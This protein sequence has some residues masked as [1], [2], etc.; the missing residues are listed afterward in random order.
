VRKHLPGAIGLV[1]LALL[2][3]TLGFKADDVWG[4]GFWL[5]IGLLTAS[6]FAFLVI[7]TRRSARGNGVR[8]R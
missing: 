7:A 8:C 2:E 1:L 5:G 6:I 4:R 3:S